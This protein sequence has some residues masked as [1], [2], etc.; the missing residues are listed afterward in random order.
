MKN[1]NILIVEDNDLQ[2]TL[3]QALSKRFNLSVK[4][5]KSC[6]DAVMAME[7][8]DGYH[9]ILMDLGLADLNGCDCAKKIRLIE[10]ERGSHTPI[11]AV[12]GHTGTEY[13]I[14]CHN[15]GMEGYL[16]KP[17]TIEQFGA[18]IDK[19]ARQDPD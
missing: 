15:A 18:T 9:L 2:H 7:S 14:D 11:V 17:F 16:A 10:K 5:V 4:L 6:K 13:R 19:W 3:Y 1:R 12:T 8:S